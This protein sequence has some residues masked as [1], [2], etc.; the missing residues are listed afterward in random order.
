M[1]CGLLFRLLD[2]RSQASSKALLFSCLSRNDVCV[3]FV[4][5]GLW[6]GVV[7]FFATCGK[8]SLIDAPKA[9]SARDGSCTPQRSEEYK[10]QPE[11]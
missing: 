7:F 10:G 2:L 1:G 9:E 6:V 8:E 5:V 11:T 3:G 4:L